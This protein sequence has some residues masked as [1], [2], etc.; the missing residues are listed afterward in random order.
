MPLS[1][2]NITVTA[3]NG[4]LST[5]TGL[6]NVHGNF[7]FTFTAPLV[8]KQTNITLTATATE[9]GYATTRGQLQ[10]TVNPRTFS[11]QITAP[12]T[13]SGQ[14]STVSVLVKCREDGTAV[15]GATVIMSPPTFGNFTTT[16]ATTDQTGTALFTYYAPRT[17]SQLV[18]PITAN[19]T[20]N[21][22]ANN[23]NRTTI[24]VTPETITQTGGGWSITT[25]LLIVIPIAIAVIVTILV[26]LKIIAISLGEEQQQK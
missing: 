19:L 26:K 5:S 8:N 15:A 10:I 24:T 22:Y 12:Q 6:T 25:I 23:A 3:N 13:A 9:N 17:T 4:N 18:I 20:K 7:T 14:F 2:S 16:A 21:G 11:I 1:G